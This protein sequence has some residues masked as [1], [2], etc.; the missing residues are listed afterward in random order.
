MVTLLRI[1]SRPVLVAMGLW[2]AACRPMS[3]CVPDV[4]PGRTYRVTLLE[5]Y[6]ENASVLYEPDRIPTGPFWP[7]CAGRDGISVGEHLEFTVARDPDEAQ[8]LRTCRVPYATISPREAFEVEHY[9]Y[10]G[11]SVNDLAFAVSNA[12]VHLADGCTGQWLLTHFILQKELFTEP[13]PG[14]RPP[15]LVRREFIRFRDN[16][17]CALP[18][19]PEDPFPYCADV[20]VARLEAL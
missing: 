9:G 7:S 6:D 1:L 12:R 20:W 16:P 10:F 11:H 14:K 13:V 3:T 19:E 4:E 15:V 5:V 8:E 18:G 17:M 2:T